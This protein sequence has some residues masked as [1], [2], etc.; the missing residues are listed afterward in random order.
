MSYKVCDKTF[1]TFKEAVK[2]AWDEYKID[3]TGG[4]END[5]EPTEEEKQA[6]CEELTDRINSVVL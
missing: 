5:E 4:E 6:A 2:W 3:F 1:K